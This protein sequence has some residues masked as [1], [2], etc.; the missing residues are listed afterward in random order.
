MIGSSGAVVHSGRRSPARAVV[1][2]TFGDPQAQGS[3]GVF[4]TREGAVEFVAGNRSWGSRTT[5]L[6]GE[7][8]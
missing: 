3:M 6:L 8:R 1:G 5:R 7:K 4:S 2:T